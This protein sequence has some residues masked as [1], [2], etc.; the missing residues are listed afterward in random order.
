MS[1]EALQ[2]RA[3]RVI[4][5]RDAQF[6]PEYRYA[7]PYPIPLNVSNLYCTSGFLTTRQ[8]EIVSHDASSLAEA[9]ARRT[10][11][12]VEVTESFCRA[13]ALAHETTNCLAWFAPKEALEAATA[14]DQEMERT[15]KPVGPL[16]GVPIS[17]KDFINVKGY[18]QSAGHIASA[19]LVPEQDADIVAVLRRAGAGEY[20]VSS[21]LS[22][23]QE[24]AESD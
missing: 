16:H 11:T 20:T 18:P 23:L 8:I 24:S 13:A 17:V 19:G 9:I 21:I 1:D 7:P 12:S 15:G 2:A 10:Y 14:L 22:L 6:T 5:V 4:A 3:A